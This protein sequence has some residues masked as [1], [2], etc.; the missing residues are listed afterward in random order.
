MTPNPSDRKAAFSVPLRDA[1][2]GLESLA[3]DFGASDL[4]LRAREARE[5]LDRGEVW[6]VVVGQ[7]KRGK[8][9]LLNALLQAP[10]LP[11]GMIPVTSVVTEIRWAPEPGVRIGCEGGASLTVPLSELGGYVS[12]EGNPGNHKGVQRVQVTLPAPV[13]EGGLVLVDTPGIGSMD[14]GAT[15]RAYAFLPRVD[16]ALVVLSPDPPVGEAEGA[17]L[18]A[19]LEHTPHLVFAL[20]KVDLFP[21]EAWREA[22]AFNR[23]ALARVQ[24]GDPEKVEL[25]P[26]SAVRAMDG[27]DGGIERLRERLLGLVREEGE[28]VSRDVAVR[29]LNGVAGELLARLEVEER[30]IRLSEESLEDRLRRLGELRKEL[31]LRREEA[32]PVLLDA[33]RRLVETA[34]TSLDERAREA[35][36]PLTGSL[37]ACLAGGV[38]LRNGALARSVSREMVQGVSTT[39]D[40]WW[41]ENGVEVKGRLRDA[42]GRAARSVDATGSTLITWVQE[43]LGV[44]LP[45]PPP[46]LDLLDSHDF[47][48]HVEG[49]APELTVDLLLLLLPRPVFRWWLRKKI[50]R[51]VAQN[52]DLNVGRTRGDLLYR[53]QETVRGFFS[54]LNQRALEAE[55]GIQTALVRALRVRAGVQEEGAGELGRLARSRGKV[56]ELLARSV[57]PGPAM[58]SV[59][60]GSGEEATS[61]RDEDG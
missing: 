12:E 1:L 29:R 40:S 45:A 8:S 10:V 24:G 27:E 46:P 34:T 2:G 41:T 23:T 9:T 19:L 15:D 39:F 54:E 51:L 57:S 21:E 56:E 25:I 5:P 59:A 61:V 6:V 32:R 52:L 3:R 37:E 31:A 43:E 28:E 35:S 50:P 47:Y 22:V 26:V 58:I 33:T 55:E 38:G 18:R 4:A 30:A 36:A 14:A 53:A 20:N 11:T 7:F 44:V 16:A 48:Y 42:M 49:L 17:Y 13:L 60:G